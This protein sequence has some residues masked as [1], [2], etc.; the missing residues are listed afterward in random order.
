MAAPCCAGRCSRGRRVWPQCWAT[1]GWRRPP[2]WTSTG[3]TGAAGLCVEAEQRGAQ[4]RRAQH[5][6]VN[7]RWVRDKVVRMPFATH[8]ATRCM[9]PRRRPLC[10]TDARSAG[11]RC[12]RCI[13]AKTEVRF[14][15][16]QAVHQFVRRT[17]ERAMSGAAGSAVSA[18]RRQWMR[19]SSGFCCRTKLFGDRVT[20]AFARAA[21]GARRRRVPIR[22]QPVA[23]DFGVAERATQYFSRHSLMRLRRHRQRRPRALPPRCRRS[24]IR[25]ALRWRNCTA[26]TSWRR[27]ATA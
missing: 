9:V 7:G 24:S 16:S 18:A 14:R 23:F 27:T 11:G 3:L 4:P 10:S 12:Q 5:L 25:W 21:D 13:R 1:N 22:P 19:L 15:D 20:H 26:S 17:V 2:L 6:F 8:C